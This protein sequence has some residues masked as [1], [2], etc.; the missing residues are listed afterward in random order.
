MGQYI[1]IQK[2]QKSNPFSNWLIIDYYTMNFYNIDSNDT[3]EKISF[4]ETN[5]Q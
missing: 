3:K 4:S 5:I 2:D 1:Q